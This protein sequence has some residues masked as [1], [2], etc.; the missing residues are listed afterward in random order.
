MCPP[1]DPRRSPLRASVPVRPLQF[2]LV[3]DEDGNSK[4][5]GFADFEKLESAMKCIKVRIPTQPTR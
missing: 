4:G 5:Y 3:K 1:S 2:R